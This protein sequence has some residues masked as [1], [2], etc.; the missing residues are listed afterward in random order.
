MA[1]EGDEHSFKYTLFGLGGVGKPG[2]QLTLRRDVRRD[3]DLV[4]IQRQVYKYY[5][6]G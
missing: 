2:R 3:V 4:I 1:E 5:R 6:N